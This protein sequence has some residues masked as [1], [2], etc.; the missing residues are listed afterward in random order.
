MRAER[1]IPISHPLK[2]RPTGALGRQGHKRNFLAIFAVDF[3]MAAMRATLTLFFLLFP[4]LLL[5]GFGFETFYG[6]ES[7]NHRNAIR[8]DGV[9][10]EFINRE[11]FTV[12]LAANDTFASSDADG[13]GFAH[14]YA[15]SIGDAAILGNPFGEF[16]EAYSHIGLNFKITTSPYSNRQPIEVTFTG[17][18][19]MAYQGL[20]AAQVEAYVY[21]RFTATLPFGREDLFSD[22]IFLEP[23]LL[24]GGKIRSG[25]WSQTVTLYSDLP[26]FLML[27]AEAEAYENSR[28]Q[29]FIDP[30]VSF[31]TAT[32]ASIAF[33]SDALMTNSSYLD[34]EPLVVPETSSLLLLLS[35]SLMFF[36][37]SR[38]SNC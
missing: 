15:D 27:G 4:S 1:Q 32:G 36:R 20:G 19:Y 34:F 31:E 29:A 13:Q 5:A 3:R 6:F 26:Y 2:P 7:T 22:R 35:A 18:Y 25:V 24:P 16:T 30:I 21:D 17:N 10:Y 33:D 37:R 11:P 23:D 28:A 38:R 14:A 12:R 9:D 8:E